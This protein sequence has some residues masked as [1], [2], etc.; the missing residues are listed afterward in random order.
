M[1]SEELQAKVD[2]DAGIP[3]AQKEEIKAMLKDGRL[4]VVDDPAN[5]PAKMAGVFENVS[6]AR[7]RTALVP[8]LVALAYG[9]GGIDGTHFD[10]RP[11]SRGSRRS[12]RRMRYDPE[13]KTVVVDSQGRRYRVDPKGTIRRIK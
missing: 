12:G 13:D 5:D 7:R 8:A 6:L 9:A 2:C 10:D 4:L 3:A 1:T 11:R